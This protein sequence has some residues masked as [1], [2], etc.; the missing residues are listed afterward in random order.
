[1]ADVAPVPP[2]PPGAPHGYPPYQ[3]PPQAN[4]M[5]IA[6]MILGIIGLGGIPLVPAA[7]ALIFGYKA[8][9]SIDESQGRESGRGMAVAG[10]VLGYVGIVTSALMAVWFWFFFTHFGDVFRD[11]SRNLPTP[12]PSFGSP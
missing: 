12:P 6:S 5:A 9:R 11:I 10:I 2:P 8:R 7:L 3:A 4:G 1:M